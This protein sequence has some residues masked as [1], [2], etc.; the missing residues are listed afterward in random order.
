MDNIYPK[1]QRYYMGYYFNYLKR[2]NNPI[3]N[4]PH[5]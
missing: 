2:G 3:I 4:D 5:N 1:A